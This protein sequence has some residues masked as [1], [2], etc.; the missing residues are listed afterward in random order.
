MKW[1]RDRLRPPAPKVSAPPLDPLESAM[2]LAQAM[3][4][5]HDAKA[6]DASASAVVGRLA[7]SRIRNGFAPAIEASIIKRHLGGAT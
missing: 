5:R 7:E 3:N 2:D 4:L 6:L 1:F